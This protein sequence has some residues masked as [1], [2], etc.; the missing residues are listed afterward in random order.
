MAPGFSNHF[1]LT[2]NERINIFDTRVTFDCNPAMNGGL[3]AFA[4]VGEYKFQFITLSK[5]CQTKSPSV[6]Q[7]SGPF[8]SVFSTNV[9][10]NTHHICYQQF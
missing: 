2:E 10:R 6:I 8:S 9:C 4:V 1:L 5:V 7:G 3:E